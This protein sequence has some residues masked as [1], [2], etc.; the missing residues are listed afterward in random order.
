MR[1]L[2]CNIHRGNF[3][4]NARTATLTARTHDSTITQ[5]NIRMALRGVW[6]DT[7]CPGFFQSDAKANTMRSIAIAAII[8]T[9]AGCSSAPD[10]PVPER[11]ERQSSA[12]VSVEQAEAECH[13]IMSSPATPY[14]S[15]ASCM[16]G[17]GY[18]EK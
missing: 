1:R 5:K 6:R 4:R 9:F 7:A 15:L 12:K 14:Q 16:K 17:K 18:V 13:A 10:Q 3:I 2:A 8:A 11:Y